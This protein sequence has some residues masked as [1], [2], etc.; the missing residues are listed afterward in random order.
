MKFLKIFDLGMTP[1]LSKLFSDPKVYLPLLLIPII[2]ALTSYLIQKTTTANSANKK[3]KEDEKEK[4]SNP[5]ETMT[6][7]MPIIS[8]L[9]TFNVPAGVGLYWI[10]GNVLGIGQNYITKKVFQKKKEGNV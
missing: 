10:I 1:S 2:S 4:A 9:I 3:K 5:L 8:L 7:I 6:K